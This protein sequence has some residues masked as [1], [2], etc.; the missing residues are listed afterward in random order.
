MW[1][2]L[3]PKIWKGILQARLD[4]ESH[5]VADRLFKSSHE[6]KPSSEA[7]FDFKYVET[8]VSDDHDDTSPKW[9]S[10]QNRKH[11]H[12]WI[13]QRGTV[14]KQ[15][16]S[17]MYQYRCPFLPQQFDEY[18]GNSK[19]QEV[20]RRLADSFQCTVDILSF[21]FSTWVRRVPDYFLVFNQQIW[22]VPQEFENEQQSI[23]RFDVK[24]YRARS[25]KEWGGL[26]IMPPK[27]VQHVP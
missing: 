14:T 2:L 25:R 24:A 1:D 4:W 18:P 19:E 8:R 6:K 23:F 13:R 5:K 17:A 7:F 12:H 20:H 11:R 21:Q 10:S 16:S 22:W 15:R 3:Q 27:V 9:R 26:R